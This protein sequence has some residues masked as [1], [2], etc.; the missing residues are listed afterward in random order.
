MKTTGTCRSCAER[1]E[2]EKGICDVCRVAYGPRVAELLA[3]CQCDPD[4]SSAFLARLPAPARERFAAL[5]AAKCMMAGPRPG[6][7]YTRSRVRARIVSV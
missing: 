4:F 7:S 5:L 3:R 2:L 1:T 6:L